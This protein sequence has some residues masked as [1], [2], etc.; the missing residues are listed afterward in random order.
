MGGQDVNGCA[1]S[2]PRTR[3]AVDEVHDGCGSW[4]RPAVGVAFWLGSRP[5]VGVDG[6]VGSCPW[7]RLVVD[8]SGRG[9]ERLGVCEAVDEFGRRRRRP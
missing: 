9:C 2:R 1:G 6:S 7:P 3:F 4:T 5:V 8:E